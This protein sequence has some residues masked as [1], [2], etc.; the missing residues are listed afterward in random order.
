VYPTPPDNS[1]QEAAVALK[2]SPHAEA[3]MRRRGAVVQ[4]TPHA[5]ATLRRRAYNLTTGFQLLHISDSHGHALVRAGK[6][7]VVYLGPG[8]PRVTEEEIDRI[9]EEGIQ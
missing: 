9:L 2:S 8:S 3:T 7:R 1:T 6:I 4:S 5:E